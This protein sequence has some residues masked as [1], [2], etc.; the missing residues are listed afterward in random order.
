MMAGLL[1]VPQ[2]S[3]AQ[4]WKQTATV[5]TTVEEDQPTH[6]FLDTLVSV[7][8]R[9]ERPVTVRRHPDANRQL[10][11]RA[12]Q[13]TLLQRGLGLF[14]ANRVLIHYTFTIRGNRFIED[15]GT[16]HYIYRPPEGA[17][18]VPL[19]AVSARDSLVER[20]LQQ[21]GYPMT[22]NLS[23]MRRFRDELS[24]AGLSLDQGAD[25]V[26]VAGR[27]V[28]SEFDAR[29]KALLRRLKDSIYNDDKTYVRR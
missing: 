14:S 20:V 15:I 28:Q 8:Q 25:V 6:T 3:Q 29:R 4:D 11:F 27:T 5:L 9:Q 24:F 10:T 19:L 22:S 26:T 17:L 21:K 18:D 13:D 2:R 1:A 12:L 23:A 7:M 16:M